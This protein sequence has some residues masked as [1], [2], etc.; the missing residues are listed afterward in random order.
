MRMREREGLILRALAAMPFVD[1]LELAAVTGA[2]EEAAH[3]ALRGLRQAGLADFTR[4]ASPLTA[5]TGRWF[6]TTE[7]LWFLASENGTGIERLLRMHPVSAHWRRILLARLDAVAVVYR[8]AS[9]VSEAVGTPRFRWYRA[10]PLDAAITLPDGRTVGVMRQGATADRTSFS[11]RVRRLLDPEQSRPRALLALMP[12]EAR[13]RQAR[14]LL[15]HHPGPVYLSPERDAARLSADD[16]V[17]HGTSAPNLLSLAE[18][19][20]HLRPGGTLPWEAPASR[21]GLP[22][23]ADLRRVDDY[24]ADHL[25]P[26]LLKPAE[27]RMLDSLADWPAIAVEDLSGILGLSD[28]RTW[29]LAARLG[30]LGL[31]TPVGLAG[32]R[33]F[34]LS[35]GGLALL[36]RRDRVSVGAAYRRWSVETVDGQPPSSWRDLPGARTRPL[37]RTIEHTRAVHRFMAALVRQAKGARGYSVSQVSPPHHSARYFRYG[38]SLRSIHPDGFGV[39]SANGRVRPFFLEW[40]RRALNPSTMAARLAPYLR[41][42]SSNRP[43]DDHGERPLVL[44]AFEDPLAEANFLGVARREMERTGVRLPLW[45]SHS[46]AL[47][48]EG[49]LGEAWRSPDVLAP[50]R[51]FQQNGREREGL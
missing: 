24:A 41:Y 12:D 19:L 16:R 10:A 37:A 31:V 11:D 29:R 25:L 4:H 39:V 28:S 46:V 34:A 1:R 18:I 13:L 33:R 6:V 44:V 17:W 50:V 30:R 22:D 36:A 26:A 42:Y 21:L 15:I 48:N 27:K 20:A 14:R 23:D 51:I 49:P 35:D 8:L 9:A 47:E 40:E 45:V 7:G 43:L 2:Y 5:S 3:V 38:G 32:R